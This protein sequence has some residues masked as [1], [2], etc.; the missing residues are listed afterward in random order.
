MTI[1]HELNEKLI[2]TCKEQFELNKNPRLG[3]GPLELIW[4]VS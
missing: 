3:S 4:V 2:P 1:Q